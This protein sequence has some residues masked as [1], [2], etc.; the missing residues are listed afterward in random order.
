ME[1]IIYFY[2]F[3]PTNLQ[4]IKV[5][6]EVYKSRLIFRF[7]TPLSTLHSF[8][9]IHLWHMF[10]FPVNVF[11]ITT[12]CYT[13]HIWLFL[14]LLFSTKCYT[15]H[16]WLFLL[17]FSTKYYMS[18][19]CLFLLLFSTKCYTSHIWLFLLLFSTKCYT[20]HICLFLYIVC[21]LSVIICCT[22]FKQNKIEKNWIELSDIGGYKRWSRG[23]VLTGTFESPGHVLVFCAIMTSLA[24]AY[25]SQQK[26]R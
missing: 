1:E 15:S 26:P 10:S 17:L 18:H 23:C 12:K 16:I 24:L 7:L 19:I 13:S 25:Y 21:T 14:L 20:S 5:I 2:G 6:L 4:H 3:Y 22:D 9:Y 11:L 8:S